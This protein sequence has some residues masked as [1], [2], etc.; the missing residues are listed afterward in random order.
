MDLKKKPAA[1]ESHRT[2]PEACPTALRP[3]PDMQTTAG[4]PCYRPTL[5][6]HGARGLSGCTRCLSACP[7]GAITSAGA[8]IRIDP[9]ACRQE[10]LCAAV[11]PTGALKFSKPATAG[12]LAG[13]QAALVKAVEAGVENPTVILHDAGLAPDTLKILSEILPK[14]SLWFPLDPVEALG[15]EIWLASLSYG[16]SHVVVLAADGISPAVFELLQTQLS[17]AAAILEGMGL[18]KERLH[19][20]RV[21]STEQAGLPIDIVQLAAVR[22]IRPSRLAP[23]EVKRTLLFESVDHLWQQSP[24]LRP[25]AALP[26]GAPFGDVLIDPGACTLCLAC[27]AVCPAQA[28]CDGGEIPQIR[29]REDRC[30][31]C[32]LCREACPESAIRLAPRMVF[33][34]KTRNCLRI[35]NQAPA[36]CCVDCGKPFATQ[37][38]VDKMVQALSGHWMYQDDAAKRR[39]RMCRECRVRN[40]FQT[41]AR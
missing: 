31:Q 21:E 1:P 10:G 19:L 3:L 34:R 18:E 25:H 24:A 16:A 27:V 12:F 17:Y 23:A 40:F 5:C 29:F 26:E 41:N 39:L 32:G 2:V 15:M 28:L 30:L 9:E 22:A 4:G 14:E 37:A 38:M 35:L 7:T 36:I 6:A 20:A 33:D 13:A 8:V 11:C